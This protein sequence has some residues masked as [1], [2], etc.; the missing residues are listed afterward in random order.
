MITIA[1]N[2]T[3]VW[4]GG[5]NS[6]EVDY[7]EEARLLGQEKVQLEDH[8]YN[9]DIIMTSSRGSSITLTGSSQ[10]TWSIQCLPLPLSLQL[11]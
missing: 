8:R 9:N 2:I 11:L 6:Q 10:W 7:Q 5:Q 4:A 1:M 3:I